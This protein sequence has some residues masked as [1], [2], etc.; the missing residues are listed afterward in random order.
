[1]NA[2]Q[3]IIIGAAAAGGLWLWSKSR[4]ASTGT[5][6]ASTGASSVAPTVGTSASQTYD[7]G[8]LI[9]GALQASGGTMGQQTATTNVQ[10]KPIAAPG[11]SAPVAQNPAFTVGGGGTVSTAN[12]GFT[13]GGSSGP[14]AADPGRNTAEQNA[15]IERAKAPGGFLSNW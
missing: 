9:A 4:S 1:M 13:V 3:I 6:T 5:S 8:A 7:L 10:T 2:K 12:P 11:A 15:A 14:T